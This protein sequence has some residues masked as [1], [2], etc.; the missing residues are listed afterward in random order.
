MEV[1]EF[2]ED[3]LYLT[4]TRNCY[5]GIHN[6]SNPLPSKSYETRRTWPLSGGSATKDL[7]SFFLFLLLA[8]FFFASM[9]TL[10]CYS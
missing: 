7:Q 10:K 4:M 6:F 3:L 2:K 1:S 9:M 8:I 5:H